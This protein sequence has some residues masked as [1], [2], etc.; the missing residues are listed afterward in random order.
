MT[1]PSNYDILLEVQKSLNRIEDKLDEKIS[2]VDNRV[3][4]ID[5]RLSNL[6]G[7]ASLLGALS[8]AVAGVIYNLFESIIRK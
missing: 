2:K 6:E 8:G 7:K 3:D 1:R 4:G 5:S